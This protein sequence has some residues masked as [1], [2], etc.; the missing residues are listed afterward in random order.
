MTKYKTEY[1]PL[2]QIF[3]PLNTV[4]E[5]TYSASENHYCDTT[6]YFYRK[7]DR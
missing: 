4:L 6:L 7:E 5:F 3:S 1:F 2:R